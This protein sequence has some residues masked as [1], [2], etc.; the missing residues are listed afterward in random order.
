MINDYK[1]GDLVALIYMVGNEEFWSTGI[2]LGVSRA[3][4]TIVHNFKDTSPIDIT[5]IP[6]KNIIKSKK[7][8]PREINSFNDLYDIEP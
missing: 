1:K 2:V 5:K 6:I 8:I 4:L 7:V 3:I